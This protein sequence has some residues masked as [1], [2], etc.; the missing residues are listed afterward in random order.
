MNASLSQLEHEHLTALQLRFGPTA[1]WS[2]KYRTSCTFFRTTIDWQSYPIS[3]E[4]KILAQRLLLNRWTPTATAGES[5]ITEN[6]LRYADTL[7]RLLAL[8]ERDHPNRALN[9]LEKADWINLSVA[10]LFH[11]SDPNSPRYL[12]IALKEPLAVQLLERTIGVLK[13]LYHKYQEGILHDGPE[14]NLTRREIFKVL[15]P[16]MASFSIDFDDWMGGGSYGSI[17]FVVAHLL[18]ADALTVL[19]SFKTQQL[20]A[21]FETVRSGHASAT[22]RAFWT[23]SRHTKIS[24][25]RASGDKC[26]LIAT[27]EADHVMN[28]AKTELGLALHNKLISLQPDNSLFRFPWSNYEALLG[29]YRSLMTAL[30]IIFLSVMGKRGPSEVLSLRGID[31]TPSDGTIGEH[32]FMRPRNEKTGGGL[33]HEQGVTNFIDEAFAVLLKLGYV[34]KSNQTYPLFTALPHLTNLTWEPRAISHSHAH[35]WLRD[36]YEEFCDRASAKID[37]SIRQIHKSVSSHQFRHSWAEFALRKFDG[38]VEELIRQH[39]LHTYNHW[40]TKRYTG[41]KLDVDSRTRANRAYIR[42]LVPRV[43]QDS[44]AKPEFVGAMALY[45]KK[46]LSEQIAILSPEEAE[47]RILEFADE[48]L[49]LTAHEYGWCLLH[50][51][52]RQAAQCRDSDGNPAPQGTSSDKCNGCANF[53]S[54]RSSHLAKQVQ[55]VIAHMDFLEQQTWKLESLRQ[56]SRKAIDQAIQLFPEIIQI[57]DLP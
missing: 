7:L 37:F 11:T 34:D 21:Y 48:F 14:F 15:R 27:R 1:S 18:L 36:Y 4:R 2:L 31:I 16:V 23:S 55:I 29:D 3:T 41:D 17:P 46:T 50:K 39:F 26:L 24:Q 30:Y 9:Q 19:R 49:Q 44:D 53:L 57:L 56:A 8:L 52:F 10:M 25:Y 54:S 47:E 22:V 28:S 6:E 38:N 43:L 13:S 33:R 5:A 40:W 51:A 12:L 32:A 45:I 42:E 35:T 20:L